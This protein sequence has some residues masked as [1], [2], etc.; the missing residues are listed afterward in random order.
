MKN[1]TR[2]LALVLALSLVLG[3]VAFAS[4]TDVKTGDDYAEAIETL[5]ALGIIKGYEDGSFGGEKA[6]TRAEA[7]AI[8]NRIQGLEKAASGAATASLYTDVAAD[9]WALGDINLATQMGIISGDGNGK[10]RPEDQVSYQE[11]VKMLTCAVNYQPAVED[12]GG[13]PTGYLVAAQTYG[14]L[15]DTVNL[16]A[17]PA[18]RAV[19][20]QLTF[21][22]LT[23]PLMVQEGFGTNKTYK[24]KDAEGATQ[25]L[26]SEKLKIYKADAKVIATDK[27]T[28]DVGEAKIKIEDKTE[29]LYEVKKPNALSLEQTVVVGNSTLGDLNLGYN[30]VVYLQRNDDREWEV[31]YNTFKEGENVEYVVAASEIESIETVGSRRYISVIDAEENETKYYID[32]NTTLYVKGD[33][34]ATPVVG[35]DIAIES[36]DYAGESIRRD[37][38][39]TFLL[40]DVND[41]AIDSIYVENWKA[42]IVEEVTPNGKGFYLED[43]TLIDLDEE[44]NEKLVYSLTLDGAEIAVTDLKEDDVVTYIVANGENYYNI[45]VSRA[46]VEG[47][48]DAYYDDPTEIYTIAGSDYEVSGSALASALDTGM[49]QEA[50]AGKSGIFYLDAF[51]KIVGYTKTVESKGSVNYGYIYGIKDNTDEDD[52][53]AYEF[54]ARILTKDGFKDID[55]ADKVYVSPVVKS[56]NDFDADRVAYKIADPDAKTGDVVDAV[57]FKQILTD[58]IIA[59]DL[60]DYTLNSDGEISAIAYYDDDDA[61]APA[62]SDYITNNGTVET[63]DFNERNS[64]LGLYSVDATTVVFYVGDA[65]KDEWVVTDNSFF[66]DEATYTAFTV[67]TANEDRLAGAILIKGADTAEGRGNLAVYVKSATVND[68]DGNPVTQIS[69]YE[70]GELKTINADTRFT[71]IKEKLTTGDVIKFKPNNQ[72]LLTAIPEVVINEAAEYSFAYPELSKD[73][74]Y[75]YG[76]VVAK[77]GNTLK[78]GTSEEDWDSH[79][80]AADAKI[81]IVEKKANGKDIVVTVGSMA[82]IAKN[83]YYGDKGCGKSNCTKAADAAGMLFNKTEADNYQVVLKYIE[84]DV[85]DVVVYKNFE[86]GHQHK[87]ASGNEA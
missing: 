55:F 51:G 57:K 29:A 44:E 83:R 72:G 12:L 27:N 37:G 20:A 78:L 13:W 30:V 59:K 75:V 64:K 15:E 23:A 81:Y 47:A 38:N 11:M 58:E 65:D 50:M 25:T 8:V 26:L 85:T 63:A 34:D 82:E 9:H 18:N 6:I 62:D 16:G 19:V 21:N 60:I 10:F 68:E 1:L 80:V 77:S 40:K 24:V 76:A 35:D 48:V 31:L 42:G 66:Q 43:G 39:V 54:T 32:E 46:T 84:G 7:V 79:T 5:A 67:Y 2:V 71:D 45:L 69:Y 17:A 3:T 41:D 49:K 56:G 14:I 87:I 52:A 61:A 22:T 53:F 4:F 73:A 86:E 33:D 28:A 74:Q 36:F 70:A